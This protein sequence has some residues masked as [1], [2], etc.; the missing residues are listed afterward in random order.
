MELIGKKCKRLQKKREYGRFI[1]RIDDG[2]C[3]QEFRFLHKY[4]IIESIMN[5]VLLHVF[6]P[7]KFVLRRYREQRF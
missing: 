5:S 4:A 3:C 2:W 6:G 7:E 1:I